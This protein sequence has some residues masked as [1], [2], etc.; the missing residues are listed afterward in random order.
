MRLWF[1][2]FAERRSNLGCSLGQIDLSLLNLALD[3]PRPFAESQ[4]NL[5]YC[6]LPADFGSANFSVSWTTRQGV[7]PYRLQFFAHSQACAYAKEPK[8][9]K[10]FMR[11]VRATVQP[12]KTPI[13][14][15]GFW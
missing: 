7:F 8:F 5:L 4:G 14:Q 9:F 12:K 3:G 10:R 6:F 1:S 15:I 11:A 13:I 2:F